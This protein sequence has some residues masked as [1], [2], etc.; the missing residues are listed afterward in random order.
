MP[1]GRETGQTGKKDEKAEHIKP[2][3]A[4]YANFLVIGC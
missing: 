1:S 4:F 3:A 2:L